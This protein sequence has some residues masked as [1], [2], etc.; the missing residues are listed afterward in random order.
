MNDLGFVRKD[1]EK[2]FKCM[3]AYVDKWHLWWLI[4][5][6]LQKL[7]NS[8]PR[9]A[10]SL[11]LP[12]KWI[13]SI[14]HISHGFIDYPLGMKIVL[15][16]VWNLRCLEPIWRHWKISPNCQVKH[17]V[18]HQLTWCTIICWIRHVGLNDIQCHHDFSQVLQEDRT[19]S[20]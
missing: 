3:N 8:L 14:T 20:F 16:N 4:C 2:H 6:N 17:N 9:W 15:G 10:F 19:G 12:S 18:F 1:L 7:P 13:A 11:M 5:I